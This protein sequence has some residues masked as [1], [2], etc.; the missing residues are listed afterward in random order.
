MATP[1]LVELKLAFPRK[2]AD[3]GDGDSVFVEV[4]VTAYG[5]FKLSVQDFSETGH[6]EF[7]SVMGDHK[8]ACVMQTL[9]RFV[10]MVRA[11][12]GGK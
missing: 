4:R 10:D 7:L 6:L 8:S 5:D 3:A 12:R 1:Q 11:S 9:E 2:K